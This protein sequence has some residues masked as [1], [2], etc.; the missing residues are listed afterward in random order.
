LSVEKRHYT[1]GYYVDYRLIPGQ[2][3][4]TKHLPRQRSIP[5]IICKCFSGQNR[6]W[7]LRKKHATYQPE[8]GKHI[9]CRKNGPISENKENKI[10]IPNKAVYVPCFV[11]KHIS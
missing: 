9:H 4:I 3:E 6:Y 11:Y 7:M 10:K 8:K 5:V 1:S 2:T